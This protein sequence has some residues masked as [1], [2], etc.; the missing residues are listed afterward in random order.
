LDR[1]FRK[2]A[3]ANFV[4]GV[5]KLPKTVANVST[6]CACEDKTPNPPRA[7]VQLAC[8]L[9]VDPLDSTN[10]YVDVRSDTC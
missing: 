8:V 9:A 3:V 4:E 2:G 6:L 5:A 1:K 7:R 10:P